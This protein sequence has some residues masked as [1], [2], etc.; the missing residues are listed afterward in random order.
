M[1]L[2]GLVHQTARD[3]L[4][5]FTSTAAP[6]NVSGLDMSTPAAN[7]HLAEICIEYLSKNDEFT[8]IQ[9]YRGF[10][11]GSAAGSTL[12]RHPFLFCAAENCALHVRAVGTPDSKL[13]GLV[14]NFLASEQ[15]RNRLMQLVYHIN[16][17]ADHC[18]PRCKHP[19]HLAAYFNLL[20]LVDYYILQDP[21]FVHSE[22][23]TNGTPLI[24]GAEIGS[25][26]CVR[27]LLEAG[28]DPNRV[29][30]DGWSPLHWARRNGHLHVAK[31][32]LEH[33]ARVL[34]QD[35]IDER[36][37]SKGRQRWSSRR[38]TWALANI[39]EQWGLQEMIQS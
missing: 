19:L 33:G 27:K 32:L 18:F 11:P 3:F 12:T 30:I 31:L 10:P 9:Y 37:D 8:G 25:I 20:W 26:E 21:N 2:S 4:E 39:F 34:R 28:A 6:E 36:V 15:Q 17:R 13:S 22:N 38:K 7:T 16:Y 35:C 5:T 29:E 14:I 1:R 23:F 24:W